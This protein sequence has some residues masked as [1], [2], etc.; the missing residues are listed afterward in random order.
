MK[1]NL[2]HV[3]S[4]ISPRWCFNGH[5]HTIAQSLTGDTGAA[6]RVRTYRNS[7]PR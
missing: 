3:P 5:L 1:T 4:F 2:R 6:P 7:H